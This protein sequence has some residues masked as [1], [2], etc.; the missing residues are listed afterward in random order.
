[1]G[2]SP[3]LFLLLG[4][5][6]AGATGRAW[7]S[8]RACRLLASTTCQGAPGLPSWAGSPAVTPPSP[9]AGCSHEESLKVSQNTGSDQPA[10]PGS[11]AMPGPHLDSASRP[12]GHAQGSKG[13]M[14][15]GRGDTGSSHGPTLGFPKCRAPFWA[16]GL[17]RCLMVLITDPLSAC[18]AWGAGV[19][20]EG[21]SRPA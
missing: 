13:H 9:G 16:P 12:L 3:L 21:C 19:G 5:S 11:K 4:T 6:E 15:W 18:C 14:N 2:W 1:M 20:F 8:T 7:L 17:H 10:L